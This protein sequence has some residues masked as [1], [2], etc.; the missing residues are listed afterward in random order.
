MG[1]NLSSDQAMLLQNYFRRVVLMLAGD[2]AG[3]LA[4]KAISERLA[5][6]IEVDVIALKKG[7]QPDQFDAREP[8]GLLRGHARE[9]RGL[10][11]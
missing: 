7:Q 1:S 8:R 4:A 11:R 9:S 10:S 5:N 6:M 2:E 3:Q